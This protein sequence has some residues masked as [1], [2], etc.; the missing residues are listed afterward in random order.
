M[1]AVEITPTGS[2]PLSRMLTQDGVPLTGA[3]VRCDVRRPSDG[4]VLD[5]ADSTFKAVGAVGTRYRTLTAVDAVEWPGLYQGTALDL[6]TIVG[7][8]SVGTVLVVTYYT[9]APSALTLDQDSLTVVNWATPTNITAGTIT[10]VGT[11][12]A[13]AADAVEEIADGVW[14]EILTGATHNIATSAG[15]RLRELSAARVLLTGTSSAGTATTIT[16]T[17]GVAIDHTYR[18]AMVTITAGT[19]AGQT[20]G[21]LDY[22]GA[23]KVAT[24]G[25]AW[26]T[27]PDATSEFTVVPHAAVDIVDTGRL[28]AA[29]STT[30]QLSE[31]SSAVN[32]HYV[33]MTLVLLSGTGSPQSRV[34]TA[35]AG[36]T[37]TATVDPAWATTPDTTSAYVIL[38]TALSDV[39]TATALAAVATDATKSRRALWNRRALT[40]LGV[41][42][43]Y[44]DDAVTP[45]ATAT[46]TDKDGA[47]ITLATG[48]AARTTAL[49]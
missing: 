9:T 48:D 36:A 19:G 29:T 32:G 14:D 42:T 16:L 21:I 13:L 23:T 47:A 35:Y 8:V 3:T 49:T 26:T 20:R 15:R 34:I 41:F 40:S 2:E 25:P 4:L 10:T 31:H 27:T 11:V 22:A 39:A 38:G 7:G 17:G 45:L 43:L 30:A 46:V 33:G 12:N 6:S 18:F 44:A 1:S 5:F 24:V 37:L 28:D